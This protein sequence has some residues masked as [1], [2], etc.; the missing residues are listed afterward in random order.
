SEND[1]P[2]WCVAF[3]GAAIAPFATS[4]GTGDLY[5]LLAYALVLLLSACFAISHR[6]WP[7][8]WRVFYLASGLFVVA[9]AWLA[10]TRDTL[11]E[12]AVFALPLVIGAAGI[13][14]FAPDSRKR[15]ALRWLAILALLAT[16]SFDRRRT[17]TEAWALAFGVLAAVA[18]WLLIIDR[19]GGVAQSS[20]LARNA[21]RAPM[22]D[23]IDS[24]L[25]PLLF[26]LAAASASAAG[27]GTPL[28]YGIAGAMLLAAA[29]RHPLG[30]GRDA[31][32]FAVTVVAIGLLVELSLPAPVIR[33]AAFLGLAVAVL[34]MHR[35]R[36]SIAWMMMGAGL[37]VFCATLSM[38]S[39]LG[40][41]IYR[42]PP[43]STAPSVSALLVTAALV[44]VARFWRSL[45]EATCEALTRRPRRMYTDTL[46]T[47]LDALVA[48]P[49][50][51]AFL[52]VLV[53]LAMAYS[54][55][56]STLLLVTYFAAT[57]VMAVAVGRMRH[58][59]RIRQLG[60]GLALAAAATSVYGASTYFDIGVRI[61]AYLVTSAF[62]LGIAYWY[63]RPGS[64]AVA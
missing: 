11:A 64:A 44:I 61:V 39:L 21:G 46:R 32:A 22:L 50:A 35:V 53:E 16:L 23:W 25:L 42:I 57:A 40:R 4:N 36:P 33:V 13:L 10:N 55:S 34:A 31:S 28:I 37:L 15:A 43:F 56:T 62:L 7:V 17:P 30:S 3:G 51:W 27:L 45:L 1:E 18:L 14:P 24:A 6:A 58:S 59:A 54:P 20:L 26:V 41:E 5:A 60:L 48:A 49:W 29:W 2:L 8:A 9:G 52:W 12:G 19:L 47:M 38:E 63:R